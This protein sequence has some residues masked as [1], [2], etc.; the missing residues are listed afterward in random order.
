M[1]LMLALLVPPIP[2]CLIP[3]SSLPCVFLRRR[4]ALGAAH[5]IEKTATLTRDFESV[6]SVVDVLRRH[7][8]VLGSGALVDSSAESLRA[9]LAL[10]R[11]KCFSWR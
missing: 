6:Q 1:F 5:W 8:E 10:M 9:W 7:A 3:Y 2:V 11:W 4:A